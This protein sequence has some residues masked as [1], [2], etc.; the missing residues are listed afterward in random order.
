MIGANPYAAGGYQV[1]KV[2]THLHTLHSDGHDSVAAMLA[3]CHSAG[4]AAVALTDHNTLSGLHEAETAAEQLGLV[5]LPGV[6]VTTFRGH[7]VVLGITRVPEWRDLEA[8]GLDAL[9]DDV[10]ADGGLVCVSHPAALGSPVCSGC[11]WAWPVQP[12]SVDLWEVFSAPRARSDVSAELWR[13]LLVAGGHAAPVAAGDVH[14]VSA[15]ARS[16]TA[17]YV[18]A[19]ER[20]PAGVIEALRER[21]AYA[22][23]GQPLDF[24]LE[25]GAGDVALVGTQV[26]DEPGGPGVLGQGSGRAHARPSVWT[27]RCSAPGAVV[28]EVELPGWGRCLYAER[29]DADQQLEAVSASIWIAS[30]H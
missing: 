27:P 29:R 17:T 6:E 1:L 18:Y 12:A 14:A 21:R 26:A 10:H 15:A 30:S 2:E 5:L 4:Y 25:D 3:A 7:A 23:A 9:A 11:T 8:R 22:S 20:S 24:W 13:Q 19:R 28:R 16:K